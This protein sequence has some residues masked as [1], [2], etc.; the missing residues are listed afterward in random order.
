ME[1]PTCS[2]KT[3]ILLNPSLCNW[4]FLQ[5]LYFDL[6]CQKSNN[7]IPSDLILNLFFL[8]G[9]TYDCNFNHG[10]VQICV[11]SRFFNRSIYACN[12]GHVWIFRW[13]YMKVTR[14]E[15]Q[16][17]PSYGVYYYTMPSFIS[18]FTFET[19]IN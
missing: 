6:F 3:Q 9:S 5:L 13:I 15:L 8:R 10:R 17:S 19:E 11:Q 14:R 1:I 4:Y 7:R 18:S 16:Y 2:M 12:P